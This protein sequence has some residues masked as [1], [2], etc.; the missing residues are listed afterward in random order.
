VR[1]ERV[2]AFRDSLPAGTVER[3]GELAG[4]LYDRAAA[5][6]VA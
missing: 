2:D 4:D 5:V 3:I 6:A 1:A